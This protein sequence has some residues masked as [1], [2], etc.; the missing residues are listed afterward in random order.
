MNETDDPEILLEEAGC[1][2]FGDRKYEL[3]AQ[4]V[5][6]CD[7]RQDEPL[8]F[9]ARLELADAA[10]FGGRPEQAMLALGWLFARYDRSRE[11]FSDYEYDLLWKLKHVTGSARKFPQVSTVQLEDMYTRMEQRFDEA[12]YGRRPVYKIRCLDACS[13]GDAPTAARW[14]E[15][16]QSAERDSM[17]DCLACDFN[18]AVSYRLFQENHEAALDCAQPLLS[19]KVRCLEVPTITWPKLLRSY[20]LTGRADEAAALHR[21][22]YRHV[23]RNREFVRSVGQYLAFRLFRGETAGAVRLFEKHVAWAIESF[24]QWRTLFFYA[25]AHALFARLAGER[26]QI[27]LALPRQFPLYREGGTYETAAIRDW[28]DQRATAVASAFDARNGTDYVSRTLR[29]TLCY[30]PAP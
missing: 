29:P 17:S 3:L 5:R 7:L 20:C 11:E 27:E 30:E 12:G 26:P 21:A 10:T 19:G 22:H 24:E 25:P 2:D 28:C 1:L 14:Y 16:W 6:L 9:Q 8:G 15:A 13:R 23:A 4:A 18:S